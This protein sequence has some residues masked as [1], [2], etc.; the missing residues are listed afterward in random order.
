[1]ADTVPGLEGEGKPHV[2]V[3]CTHQDSNTV[4]IEKDA[5]YD[6]ERVP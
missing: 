3:M 2:R 5:S 4:N 1:M 6:T